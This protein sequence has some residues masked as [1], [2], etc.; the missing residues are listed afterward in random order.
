MKTSS[1]AHAACD[2]SAIGLSMLCL[3][4]CLLLPVLAALLPALGTWAQAEWVH[5]VFAAIA[6]PL[7]GTALWRAHRHRPLPPVLVALALLGLTGLVAGAVLHAL[8]TPLTVT[9]SLLLA[10]AHVWNW[11]R[12]PHATCANG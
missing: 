8:E 7:A 12:R 1:A 10:S 5:P 9:G 11:R 2:A 3:A 6:A 4:H